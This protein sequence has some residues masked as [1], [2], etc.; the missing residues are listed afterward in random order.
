MARLATEPVALDFVWMG[1]SEHRGTKH[2]IGTQLKWIWQPAV[3][4][5]II[6]GLNRVS[7]MDW[8]HSDNRGS[9][10]E[11]IYSGSNQDYDLGDD[12]I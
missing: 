11:V 3:R 4:V 2:S 12:K 9:S 6:L 8:S 7:K 10:T 1:I 5:N